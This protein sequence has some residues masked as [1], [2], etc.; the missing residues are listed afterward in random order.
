M[1]SGRTVFAQLLE[2]I[3]LYRFRQLVESYRADKRVR[4]LSAWTQFQALI[5]AQ[6]TGRASLRAIEVGL[7]S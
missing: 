5:F 3:P 1:P 4:T 2:L 7:A 6:L